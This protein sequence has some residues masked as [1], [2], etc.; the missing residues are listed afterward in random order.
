MSFTTSEEEQTDYI[1]EESEEEQV[2]ELNFALN[3][4]LGSV[5]YAKFVEQYPNLQS[6]I[7]FL[8]TRFVGWAKCVYRGCK[9]LCFRYTI[10]YSGEYDIDEYARNEYSDEYDEYDRFVGQ[11][12]STMKKFSLTQY[13]D[14]KL[15][16][17]TLRLIANVFNDVGFTAFVAEY[18][19]HG[20]YFKYKFTSLTNFVGPIKDNVVDETYGAVV[21][22]T[23]I[24][25]Y[26][27]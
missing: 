6:D 16:N 21:D 14:N 8:A 2:T 19:D 25:L 4:I 1:T 24:C 17:E 3:T 23:H 10:P 12:G 22:H 27:D 5:Q 18:N 15:S 9:D 13:S 20:K 11:I 26:F 7:D